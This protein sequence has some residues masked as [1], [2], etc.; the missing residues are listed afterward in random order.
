MLT[1]HSEPVVR[2]QEIFSDFVVVDFDRHR[3]A[4]VINSGP[5]VAA[6]EGSDRWK[7]L[8]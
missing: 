2:A 6:R 5:G 3:M 1:G 8:L 4:R 7:R